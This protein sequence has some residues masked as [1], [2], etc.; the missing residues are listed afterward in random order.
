MSRA[1]LDEPSPGGKRA[2]KDCGGL[3]TPP[4]LFFPGNTGLCLLGFLGAETQL[5]SPPPRFAVQCGHS[6]SG[7]LPSACFGVEEMPALGAALRALLF[8]GAQLRSEVLLSFPSDVCFA[9]GCAP[10]GNAIPNLRLGT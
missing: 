10:H 4:T 1:E 7:M 9:E 2:L 3:E 8:W 6:S 5:L